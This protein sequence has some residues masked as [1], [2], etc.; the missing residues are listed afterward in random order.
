MRYRCQNASV[1]IHR[2]GVSPV[3]TEA[4]TT[5]NWWIETGKMLIS[6]VGGFGFAILLEKY[7]KHSGKNTSS[8]AYLES[9]ASALDGMADSIES[10]KLPTGNDHMF[11]HLI[12]GVGKHLVEDFD[13][14]MAERL[15]NLSRQFRRFSYYFEEDRKTPTGGLKVWM[16]DA[17]KAAGNLRAR[18]AKLRAT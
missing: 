12:S 3:L 6:G 17:R 11:F 7:K 1:G 8:A 4:T 16:I 15:E 14:P 13:E 10:G 2:Q 18:A 9:I 5:V